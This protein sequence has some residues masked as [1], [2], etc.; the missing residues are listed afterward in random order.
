[1]IKN[2]AFIV[3]CNIA[4]GAF[5]RFLLVADDRSVPNTDDDEEEEEEDEED[6]SVVSPAAG[7]AEVDAVDA[8]VVGEGCRMSF[9]VKD[10]GLLSPYSVKSDTV[11]NGR[12]FEEGATISG[13][14]N[15]QSTM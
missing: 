15:A 12:S 8:A 4:V 11:A 13:R 6:D 1:V 5:E 10:T 9:S 3:G 7:D 14:H 2:D